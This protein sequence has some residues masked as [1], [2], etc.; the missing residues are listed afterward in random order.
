MSVG[1]FQFLS[2]WIEGCLQHGSWPP[3]EQVIHETEE[4][5]R[6]DVFYDPVSEIHHHFCN[7]L[8]IKQVSP[9]DS[10]CKG[11]IQGEGTIWGHLRGRSP[12]ESYWMTPKLPHVSNLKAVRAALEL[13]RPVFDHDT[14]ICHFTL[15]QRSE[16]SKPQLSH[17]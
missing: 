7:I 14:G 12:Q 11:T 4:C 3:P 15:I 9:V 5:E 16:L 8:L 10:V 1:G 17:L 6:H 13:C 2:K